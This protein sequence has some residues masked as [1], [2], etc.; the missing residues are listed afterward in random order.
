MVMG[1][2]AMV[3]T[4][5]RMV[6]MLHARM[7]VVAMLH[8]RMEVVAM[9]ATTRLS[10]RTLLEDHYQAKC[11]GS[12]NQEPHTVHCL[13]HSALLHAGRMRGFV[14]ALTSKNTL[15]CGFIA[16]SFL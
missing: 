3:P 2:V 1:V 10:S 7:E 5:M 6:A 15:C 8:A 14:I 12:N 9:E 13:S 11:Q 4:G 16:A